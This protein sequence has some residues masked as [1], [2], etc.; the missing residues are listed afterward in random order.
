MSRNIFQR[1]GSGFVSGEGVVVFSISWRWRGSAYVNVSIVVWGGGEIW[2]LF[3]GV[4]GFCWWCV[5]VT[6]N[7]LMKCLGVL[8]EVEAAW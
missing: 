2:V 7:L 4:L 5:I 1:S 8:A 3:A 6:F